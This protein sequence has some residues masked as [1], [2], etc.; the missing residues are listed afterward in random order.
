MSN[1]RTCAIS[2][3]Q[4]S[5]HYLGCCTCNL[6]RLYSGDSLS[7]FISGYQL[8]SFYVILPSSGCPPEFWVLATSTKYVAIHDYLPTCLESSNY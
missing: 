1:I 3:S 4:I 7:E 5:I 8:H 2:G 6:S